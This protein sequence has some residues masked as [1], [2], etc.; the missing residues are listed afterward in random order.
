MAFTQ[1]D[2]DVVD[3]AIATGELR[4]RLSAPGGSYREVEYRSMDDLIKA[5]S[6]MMGSVQTSAGVSRRVPRYQQ[7]AFADE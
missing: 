2:I 4:V 3:R 5:K 1:A 7:A 6:V